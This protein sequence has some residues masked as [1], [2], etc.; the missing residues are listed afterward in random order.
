MSGGICVLGEMSRSDQPDFSRQKRRQRC[1]RKAT[2][3]RSDNNLCER[4]GRSPHR[5]R[6]FIVR[7]GVHGLY[8][9]TAVG[10]PWHVN[11]VCIGPRYTVYFTY[12]LADFYSS[13]RIF[14]LK[15]LRRLTQWYVL[16][17]R[18]VNLYLLIRH[19]K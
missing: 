12:L 19:D 16:N 15:T 9:T 10:Q 1:I 6:R 3:K 8:I 4:R 11:K 7:R 2:T 17:F 5:L 14:Q 18:H 13:R